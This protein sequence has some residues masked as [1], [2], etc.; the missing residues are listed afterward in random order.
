MRPLNKCIAT[1]D[2]AQAGEVRIMLQQWSDLPGS[3]ES[4]VA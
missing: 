4:K 3:A 1:L 2:R